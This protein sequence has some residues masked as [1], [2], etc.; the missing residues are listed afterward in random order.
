VEFQVGFSD[1]NGRYSDKSLRWFPWV[2]RQPWEFL[3]ASAAGD[4]SLKSRRSTKENRRK[5]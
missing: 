1:N 4:R 2:G 3:D 5:K